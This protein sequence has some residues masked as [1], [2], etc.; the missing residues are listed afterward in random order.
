MRINMLKLIPIALAAAIT[1][2][3]PASAHTK[4]ATANPAPNSTVRKAPKQVIITFNEPVLAR[5]VTIAVTGPGGK[6]HV[7]GAQVDP[8]NK[9][10]VSTVVHGGGKPGVYKVD[11]SAAGSDMHKMTGSY[12]FAVRP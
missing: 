7:M 1:V 3:A 6:L 4:L 5:F 10:R 2:A 8:K 11:W 12:S 9:A